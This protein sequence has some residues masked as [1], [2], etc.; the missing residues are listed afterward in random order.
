M[1]R[2]ATPLG[3]SSSPMLEVN[4]LTVE[5]H[6]GWRRPTLRAVDGVSFTVG[7][8]ETVGLVG[9]SGSGKTTIGRSILGLA[10][11]SG[12]RIELLGEDITHASYQQ[13]RRLSAVHQIVFQDP[14]SSLN[15]T[16]TIGQTLTE[17]LR[18]QRIVGEAAAVR[19]R[20]LLARVALPTDAMSRSPANFSGGQ[21]Q[22]IAIARPL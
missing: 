16:R 18:V 21:R 1:N 3:E 4:D 9:E 11:V 22:R 10:P 19:A 14:Y 5:Y 20:A 13:R 17:I 15:R 2:L 12:G 6:Q 8:G 7:F